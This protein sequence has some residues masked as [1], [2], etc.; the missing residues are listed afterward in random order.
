MFLS[1]TI[2]RFESTPV[3]DANDGENTETQDKSDND[4][5]PRSDE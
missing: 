1:H 5:P 3:G 4:L 2:S